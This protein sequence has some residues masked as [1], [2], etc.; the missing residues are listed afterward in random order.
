MKKILS[1]SFYGI[2]SMAVLSLFLWGS[3]YFSLFSYSKINKY[4][5]ITDEYLKI[6]NGLGEAVKVYFHF[7]VII[8]TY[9]IVQSLPKEYIIKNKILFTKKNI[10]FYYI[11]GVCVSLG[12]SF[13]L[14]DLLDSVFVFFVMMPVII[15]GITKGIK[16]VTTMTSEEKEEYLEYIKNLP[17][18][19]HDS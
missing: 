13:L 6:E 2:L 10:V 18:G 8:V 12:I 1:D 4:L 14:K 9:Y 15:Y 7:V 3:I 11:L 19:G 17:Q 5:N 16:E